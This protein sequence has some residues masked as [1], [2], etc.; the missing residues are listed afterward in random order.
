MP[1][2][3]AG[4][5]ENSPTAHQPAPKKG[6]N[7]LTEPMLLRSLRRKEYSSL[8]RPVAPAFPLVPAALAVDFYPSNL[9]R[10]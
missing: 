8:E 9:D 4:L 1:M 10:P 2:R 6:R 7:R 5:T 3:F